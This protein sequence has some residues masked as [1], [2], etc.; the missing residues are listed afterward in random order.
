MVAWQE[1]KCERNRKISCL[2]YKQSPGLQE[3]PGPFVFGALWIK[4]CWS[5]IYILGHC[6]TPGLLRDV[7]EEEVHPRLVQ[8][9]WRTFLRQ[10]LSKR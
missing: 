10:C 6:A 7:A 4:D 5:W 8:V 9:S 1:K 2:Q 3:L